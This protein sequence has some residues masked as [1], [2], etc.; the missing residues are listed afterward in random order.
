MPYT[1]QALILA[2]GW[3]LLFSDRPLKTAYLYRR[4]SVLNH[5]ENLSIINRELYFEGDVSFTGKLIIKG[6][7]KGTITGETI[8][9]AE[10]GDVC[11][12][13]K[14]GSITIGGDFSGEIRALDELIILSTGNC[15]GKIACKDLAVE[16]G[17]ILNAEVNCIKFKKLSE[18]MNGEISDSKIEET[19]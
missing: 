10:E 19:S 3:M 16:P 14:A 2:K 15:C 4:N 13:I 18:K 11:A 6:K 17:G 5:S 9:I 1:G 8:I 12:D 7:V